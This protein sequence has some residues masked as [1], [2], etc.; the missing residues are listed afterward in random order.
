M[1]P[2]NSSSVI[3]IPSG[4]KLCTI[5]YGPELEIGEMVEIDPQAFLAILE[6]LDKQNLLIKLM[7]YRPILPLINQDSYRCGV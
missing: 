7:G 2:F 5:H 4:H 6:D 3:C 1:Y